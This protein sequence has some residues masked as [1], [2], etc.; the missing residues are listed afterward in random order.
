M[1]RKPPAKGADRRIARNSPRRGVSEGDTKARA[2]R[3]ARQVAMRRALDLLLKG[4]SVADVAA[5][6]DVA[7]VTVYQWL[8]EPVIAE[9]LRK[10]GD[11]IV[12]SGR[13][14][15]QLSLHTAITELELIEKGATN[16]DGARVKALEIHLDRAGLYVDK[17]IDVKIAPTEA[18]ALSDEEVEKR[19]MALAAK[20]AT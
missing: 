3:G 14:R 1:A 9:A 4:Q 15:L 8:R 19:L 6:C 2:N 11:E 7:P 13:R 16:T 12:E 5:A 20:R 18:E 10:I 17:P